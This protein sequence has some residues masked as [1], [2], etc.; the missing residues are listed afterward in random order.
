[1]LC[2]RQ[3][4]IGCFNGLTIYLVRPSSIIPEYCHRFT[5]IFVQGLLV[6]FAIVPGINCSQDMTI[7]LAKIT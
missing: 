6:R 2:I 4:H 7:L 1:M 5:N 3:L